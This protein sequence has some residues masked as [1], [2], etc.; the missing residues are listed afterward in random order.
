MGAA[1]S[2]IDGAS[3]RSSPLSLC[4]FFVSFTR[5]ALRSFKLPQSFTINSQSFPSN[6]FPLSIFRPWSITRC[7]LLSA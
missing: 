2:F 7:A 1:L 5:L 4:L 6:L 3:L